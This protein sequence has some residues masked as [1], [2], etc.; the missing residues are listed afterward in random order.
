MRTVRHNSSRSSRQSVRRV[1]RREEFKS[2]SS[3]YKSAVL[4]DLGEFRLLTLSIFSR[5]NTREFLGAERLEVG[6]H[7]SFAHLVGLELKVLT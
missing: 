3:C 4:L 6:N 5:Y 1:G 7:K 2:L